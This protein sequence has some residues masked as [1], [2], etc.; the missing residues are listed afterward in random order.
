MREEIIL[1]GSVAITTQTSKLEIISI[2]KFFFIL[3]SWLILSFFKEIIRSIDP[4][5]SDKFATFEPITLPMT[6]EPLFSR[7]TKKVVSI[8]GAEVPNAITVDP[9][10]KGEKPNCF[11]VRTEYFS[12]FSALTHISPMPSTI[13]NVAMIIIFI[14]SLKFDC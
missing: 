8:S 4:K 10:K 7:D 14:S 12:N 6:I 1:N 11:A 13:A 9:I 5:T 2:N 3:L